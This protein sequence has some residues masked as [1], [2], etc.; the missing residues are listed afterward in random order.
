MGHVNCVRQRCRCR[1]HCPRRNG[2][3]ER[4]RDRRPSVQFTDRIHQTVGIDIGDGR[5]RCILH[6]PNRSVRISTHP[7]AVR[8]NAVH[9]QAFVLGAGGVAALQCRLDANHHRTIG[10]NA[11]HG[12]ITFVQRRC[13]VLVIVVWHTA[14]RTAKCRKCWH[15]A[16]LCTLC[17]TWLVAEG[18][19]SCGLGQLRSTREQRTCRQAGQRRSHC[20]GH[21]F[22]ASQH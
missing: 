3:Q 18:Q 6:Q 10:Q 20:A 5:M 16:L 14:Q 1:R 15:D 12:V 22:A 17:K 21:R 19:G 7:R 8:Q 2:R 9:D 11:K 13:V 4:L